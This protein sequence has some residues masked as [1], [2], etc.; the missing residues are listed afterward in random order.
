MQRD[1]L[2]TARVG[3]VGNANRL[4]SHLKSP[5]ASNTARMA[6]SGGESIA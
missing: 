2:P 5:V 1:C 4:I 3:Q 6:G